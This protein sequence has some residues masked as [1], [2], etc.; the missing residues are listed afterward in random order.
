MDDTFY[1]MSLFGGNYDSIL[2]KGVQLLSKKG[3]IVIDERNEILVD[4]VAS[5]L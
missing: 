4:T 2:P 3:T 1:T 5:F